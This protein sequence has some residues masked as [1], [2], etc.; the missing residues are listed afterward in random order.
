[1]YAAWAVRGAAHAWWGSSAA[2]M[3]RSAIQRLRTGKAHRCRPGRADSGERL[4]SAVAVHELL[5]GV[6]GADADTRRL[7][8]EGGVD[9]DQRG[10]KVRMAAAR[11]MATAPPML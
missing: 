10:N 7:R 1:M 4:G 11:T 2:E 6:A 8:V 5:L 9:E 3:R